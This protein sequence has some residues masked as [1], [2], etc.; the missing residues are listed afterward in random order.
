MALDAGIRTAGIPLAGMLEIL[1]VNPKIILREDNTA[2]MRIVVTG[3]SNAIRHMGR[4]HKVSIAWLS[5]RHNEGC[6]E[7][8]E[9]VSYEMA[10]DIFT[11]FFPANKAR[12]WQN[13]LRLIGLFGTNHAL[14]KLVPAP[15][16]KKNDNKLSPDELFTKLKKTKKQENGGALTTTNLGLKGPLLHPMKR[17]T[18][19]LLNSAVELTVRLGRKELYPR[20]A[21]LSGLLSMKMLP[22]TN[23]LRISF[24][25]L[26][27]TNP[28]PSCCLLLFHVQGDPSGR[29]S[30]GAS[31]EEK[32]G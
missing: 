32:K 13:D 7:L 19:S 15:K 21:R 8:Q 14:V 3:R 24:S 26:K 28:T 18:D 25:L 11:K 31:R 23:A 27:I 22:P 9:T 17:L 16:D 4:T 1:G 2:A 6:F 30:A 12:E 20:V 10:A 29:I 5:E